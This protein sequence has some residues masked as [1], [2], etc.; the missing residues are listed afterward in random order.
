MILITIIVDIM[1]ATISIMML[2]GLDQF[3]KGIVDSKRYARYKVAID[4]MHFKIE[5]G[6]NISQ[7]ISTEI[8][9]INVHGQETIHSIKDT[10]AASHFFEMRIPR[11]LNQFRNAL[12]LITVLA[13]GSVV[14]DFVRL[15]NTDVYIEPSYLQTTI[16]VLQSKWYSILGLAIL[17]ATAI[18]LRWEFSHYHQKAIKQ[19]GG[20]E[21]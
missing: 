15:L 20:S 13:C 21:N 14:F 7:V 16:S 19:L 6:Q 18:G 9:R 4:S 11:L 2:I 17:V 5:H 1:T 3:I 12:V 10:A 8:C